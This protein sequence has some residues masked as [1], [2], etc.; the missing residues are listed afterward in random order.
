MKNSIAIRQ[1]TKNK[2]E[3]RVPVTPQAVKE[4]L[5][6]GIS[7][8]VE[9]SN[10]RV[11]PDDDYLSAGATL[12]KNTNP[13]QVVIGI[14]EPPLDIIC[15]NQTH[16]CF[17]H[18]IKGQPYNLEMLRTFIERKCTL[19]DYEPMVD[20]DG[21]RV[22]SVFSVYAGIAGTIETLRV[23]AKKQLLRNKE[24][25]LSSLKAPLEYGRL[26][27]MREAVKK[28]SPFSEALR[29]VIVGGEG[30]VSQGCQL[31]LNDLD[32]ERIEPSAI[33]NQS[34][35]KSWY[36]VLDIKDIVRSR[37][38]STFN[39][40]HYLAL[41][42]DA[43]ESCFSEYLGT[44]DILLQGAYW[45]EK[46]PRQI[47][48]DIIKNTP[49]LLPDVIGDISC[50]IDGALQTTIKP[51]SIDE[52]AYTLDIST[53]ETTNGVHLVGP[54]T[55]AIDNLPCELSADASDEFSKLITR[56]IPYLSTFDINKPFENSGL[57]KELMS[58]TILYN[59]EF[60]EPFKYMEKFL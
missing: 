46:Y 34:P 57:S 53:G 56:S 18:T 20:N 9:S 28:L 45:D 37:D 51:C 60:T 7:L 11:F 59:G 12:C 48:T 24:T 41:G 8:N 33:K 32:I 47:T 38:G 3:R 50:D 39:L 58:G 6:Q 5:K 44:F 29:I 55:M 35:E 36:S 23:Y 15:K 1:E 17:S 14:K 16:L 19:V 22:A 25:V 31:V 40:S 21:N 27:T 10:I 13:F 26:K 43:Y 2:W 49:G 4:I 42:N 54:T 30:N 52:P